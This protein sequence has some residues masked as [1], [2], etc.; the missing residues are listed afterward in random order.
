MRR[1]LSAAE[2]RAIDR[3]TIEG[4]RVPGIVLMETAA[5]AVTDSLLSRLPNL[6]VERVLVLCGKG[7]NGGD[8][9]AVARQLLL[10][11][12]RLRLRTAL[13]A[14]PA[15]LTPDAAANWAM[16]AAQDHV[17][18]VVPTESAWEALLPAV[19][20][21]TIVV[22]ALL[23]TGI[24]G[25]PRGLVA[26]V[27]AD[28]N[29]GL[30]GARAVAVDMPSGLGSDAGALLGDCMRA[31][32]TVTFTAPKI[33]QVLAPACERAGELIVARIGTADSV[34]EELPG[35]RLLLAEKA[36]ARPFA[37]PRDRS[38]HKG[39]YGHVLAVGGSR[40]KPG[41]ILMTGKAALRA[42]AGLSTVATASSAAEAL[43]ATAPELMLEPTGELSDGTLGPEQ[44][45]ES[46]FTG[47]SVVAVGPGLGTS[48]ASAAL[49]QRIAAACPLPLVIDADGLAAVSADLLRKR[50][51]PTVLT[52]HPGEMGRMIGTDAASVQRD[53]VRAAREFAAH[54]GAH[55]VLKGNRTLTASPDGDVVVNPT[56]TPGMAT[57]GS[58]DVL[59]GMIAAF[60]AQFPDRPVRD[61][62]AAAVY[63][64]GAAGE[65]AASEH[66]EQGMLAT[67]IS[68]HLPE[69]I[70]AAAA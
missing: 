48:A 70:R 27:I 15:S 6:P 5:R 50:N 58:G 30:R 45:D 9:L 64:H 31:D 10:H 16:L 40:S 3:A 8:G 12:P 46:W 22:D 23:G 13:L 14:D 29:S 67:D 32:W 28:V 41:A 63:L 61:T 11:A 37:T 69:A 60:L 17:A 52:P 24:S 68:H 25:A 34:L 4:R 53:R 66:G 44:F 62:V 56:G 55:V 65:L 59:T 49:V 35:P 1:V 18:D 33:G 54:A 43:L 21:S 26:K 57:A 47:K 2:M 20:D 19:S 7:N 38:G 51:A 39:T 36:D 42:G